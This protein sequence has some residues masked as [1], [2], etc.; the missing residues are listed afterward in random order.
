[1]E[2]VI[3]KRFR[4]EA[5]KMVENKP[6]LVVKIDDCLLDFA[7]HGR[8]SKYYRKKLKGNWHGYEELQIGGDIRIIMVIQETKNIATLERIGSHSQLGLA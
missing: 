6:N 8:H 2:L 1:M 3:S 5:R 4:K 7:E